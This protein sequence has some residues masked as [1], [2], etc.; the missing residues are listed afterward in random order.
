MCTP[1]CILFGALNL[2]EEEIQGKAVIEVGSLDVNGSLRPLLESLKPKKY[3]G[4]DISKGR[5]VDVICNAEDLFQKFQKE[6]FD[7]L[8]STELLEHVRDWRRV[9]CNFKNVVKPD[10]II[11]ITTRSPG[12]H[13]HGYPYDFWRY[14]IQD[15]E[16][17][18]S[19]CIIEKI[20]KDP[21]SPGVFIKARKPR[22]FVEADLSGYSLH[23]VI[24][25]RRASSLSDEDLRRFSIH[26]TLRRRL[27]AYFLLG[28]KMAEVVK[29]RP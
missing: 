12:F 8:I 14:E 5:G 23:S 15:M 22:D 25:N 24:F 4:V 6:S 1:S 29:R 19:D 3:V 27:K 11:L 16:N 18:F 2:K 10:G 21:I 20:E 26:Y 7:V 9:I 28:F 13:Y 17:I